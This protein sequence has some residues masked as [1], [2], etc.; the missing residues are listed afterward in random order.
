MAVPE[1]IKS[2]WNQLVT[3]IL[4]STKLPIPELAQLQK[5]QSDHQEQRPV[6]VERIP[7]VAKDINDFWGTLNGTQKAIFGLFFMNCLLMVVIWHLNARL[8]ALEGRSK[9]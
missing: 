9:Y 2:Y 8:K 1:G 6:V 4:S 5:Q 3:K 7:S